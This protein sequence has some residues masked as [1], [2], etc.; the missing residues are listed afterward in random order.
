ME[1]YYHW[2][3]MAYAST[4]VGH[5]SITLPAG[6][7]L[8][9]L[10]FGLQIIGRRGEDLATLAFAQELEALFN[11]IPELSR[12]QVDTKSL[13]NAQPLSFSEGFLGFG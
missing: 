3:S 2:L 11:T 12:P 7:D 8:N 13:C 1:S 10:P 9:G 4:L 6:R 5:P